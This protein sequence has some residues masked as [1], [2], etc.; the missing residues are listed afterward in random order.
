MRA[1]EAKAAN[2]LVYTLALRTV[3]CGSLIL[4]RNYPCL[5]VLKT[6]DYLQSPLPTE[7]IVQRGW[8][9]TCVHPRVYRHVK[10]VTY[11]LSQRARSAILSQTLLAEAGRTEARASSGDFVQSLWK[12]PEDYGVDICI[13]THVRRLAIRRYTVLF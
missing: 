9:T 12:L 10:P 1:E 3:G 5:V 6:L 4:R 11:R 13:C 7:Y 2:G 8:H